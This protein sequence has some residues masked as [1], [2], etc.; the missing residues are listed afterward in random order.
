MNKKQII[1]ALAFVLPGLIFLF[2]KI[3]GNN[4]FEIP[5]YYKDG[6]TDV[7]VDCRLTTKG[8]YYLSDSLLHSVKWKKGTTLWIAGASSSEWKELN[9]ALKNEKP[10][11]VQLI[12][13]DSLASANV[14]RIKNCDL[15]IKK[16]WNTV[17]TDD[18]KRIRGY[19]SLSSRE[20][21][22]RL[23]IEIEILSKNQ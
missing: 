14:Q 15:L 8:Q 4:H 17:L 9:H 16:P 21:L 3:F 12:N 5:I 20:E 18:Q 22:D 13:L 6:L 23:E 1:L 10:R 11:M 2:L 7:P 19:Y